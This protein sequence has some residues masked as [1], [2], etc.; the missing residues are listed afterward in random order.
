[1]IAS[2]LLLALIIFCIDLLTP[3]EGA[4]AV[5]YVAVVLLLAPFGRRFI[6]AS[7]VGAASLTLLAFVSGHLMNPTDAAISRFVVS[8]IAIV[9]TT[10][11]SLR[12]RSTR[13][14]LSEQ[15]RILELSHDTVIIRDSDDVILYWNDGAEELYGWSRLEAVGKRC[16]TILQ[17]EYPED[18]V[19]AI[20][21]DAGHWSGEVIRTRRD[22]K[23][24]TLASR[25]LLRR[26]P[27]GRQIGIIETSAD[28]TEQRRADAQIKASERRY[29]TIFDFSGVAAWEAD[30]SE[31]M[32]IAT[33][34]MPPRVDPKAW[35]SART[36][37]V[38]AAANS[39]VI[40]NANQAAT[41]LFEGA[42]R[43]AL[44]GSDVRGRYLPE[45]IQSFVGVLAELAAG[46]TT[47]ECETRMKT[48][49][50]RIAHIVF[51]VTV[52]PEGERW[53]NMLIMALDVTERN[54]TRARIEQAS[55]EL[56]HAAR[57]STLGQLAA[58][59]AHEVNQPLAAIINY[60]N[61]AKRWLLRPEP[62]LQEVAES[63]DKLVA[64]ASRAAE[65]VARVRKLA[66]KAAPQVGRLDLS[67]L[68]EETL[69]LVH[70]EVQA[71]EVIVH[72]TGR[73]GTLLV[74]A[75]RVQVQQV[76]INLLMNGIQAMSNIADRVKELCLDVS[77]PSDGI[78]RIAVKDRGSGFAEG[79]MRRIFEPFYTTRAEGMGI[80]LSICQSIIES[81]GGQ[82]SAV[83]NADFGATVAFTLPAAQPELTS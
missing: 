41:G 80:G 40:R 61:S 76:L 23:R 22:G 62:D 1:L 24:L 30:W 57:I 33:T 79:D 83:N 74:V 10:I 56:A 11:L 44:I 14:T 54:E 52:L 71:Q 37:L 21:Q 53:S 3:L 34:G 47:S 51:R 66:R 45:T 49:H 12:D 67:E 75:D 59:I 20:M 46:V 38:E 18:Q 26:D 39:M 70:R 63:L 36:D 17:C 68:I 32:R 16:R 35:L 27:D 6:V 60:G 9:T 58:S 50:D 28:L 42:D 78:V 19:A 77:L 29:R 8:M 7:G 64:S 4:I 55:A 73:T 48:L 82:I 2:A 69:A 25:W 5:L 65:V 43:S 81:Q 72:R 31:T 13:T 15:A